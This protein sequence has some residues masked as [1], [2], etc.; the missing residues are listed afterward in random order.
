[1]IRQTPPRQLQ[2]R[3]TRHT[4][5]N[6]FADLEEAF[7]RATSEAQRAFGSGDL[8]IEELLPRA[9][10]IEV[11]IIGDGSGAVPHL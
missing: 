2:A 8:C 9:R 10:H 3:W 5:R 11:Q 7:N 4:T 1:V 6:G